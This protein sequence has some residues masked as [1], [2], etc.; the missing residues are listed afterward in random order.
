MI[1]KYFAEIFCKKKVPSFDLWRALDV[2]W[3]G[4]A[5]AGDRNQFR[6]RLYAVAMGWVQR[7]FINSQLKVITN[8][9]TQIFQGLV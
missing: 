8:M 5:D 9:V 6:H 1:L 7:L 3:Q 2:A 4:F